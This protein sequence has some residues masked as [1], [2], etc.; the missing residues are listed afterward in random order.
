MF[1]DFFKGCSSIHR[2]KMELMILTYG[3]SKETATTIMIFYKNIKQ[4]FVH[5]MATPTSSILSLV[6]CKEICECHVCLYLAKTMSIDL[7]K[8]NGFTLKQA[9]S[10]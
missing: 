4:G 2:R 8:E 6:S 7:I 10:R 3:L 9:R 5:L 1:K